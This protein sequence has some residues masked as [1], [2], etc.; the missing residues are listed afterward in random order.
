MLN[1]NDIII[2]SVLNF[3]KSMSYNGIVYILSIVQILRKSYNIG[4]ISIIKLLHKQASGLVQKHN[5]TTIVI[6]LIDG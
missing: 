5:N 4:T 6:I 2:I 3:L 1:N